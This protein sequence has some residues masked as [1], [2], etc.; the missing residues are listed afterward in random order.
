MALS[1]HKT[2]TA[3][4]TAVAAAAAAAAIAIDPNAG[5]PVLDNV[6]MMVLNQPKDGTL[7]K[8]LDRGGISKIYNLLTLSQ[9]DHGSLTFVDADGSCHPPLYW[10]LKS[11]QGDQDLWLL[12]CSPRKAHH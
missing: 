12:L 8:A 11:D 9:T 5:K 7:A 3:A 4:T 1:A 6:I 2:R 10:P